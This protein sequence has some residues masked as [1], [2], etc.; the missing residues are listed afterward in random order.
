MRGGLIE[1]A[2]FA[3]IIKSAVKMIMAWKSPGG[4]KKRKEKTRLELSKI[5]LIEL[6]M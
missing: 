3:Y 4:K 5:R 6:R 1:L 2:N